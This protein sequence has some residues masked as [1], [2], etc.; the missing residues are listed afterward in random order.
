MCSRKKTL[1][2]TVSKSGHKLGLGFS[3][4]A[5]PAPLTFVPEDFGVP[6]EQ[7]LEKDWQVTLGLIVTQVVLQFSE[8]T[9]TRLFS[10][11]ISDEIAK[12]SPFRLLCLN[13]NARSWPWLHSCHNW[14]NICLAIHARILNFLFLY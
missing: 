1:Q 3:D 7:S 8:M 6:G 5:A 10:L 14:V 9:K 2:C 4:L 12:F 11:H 13:M